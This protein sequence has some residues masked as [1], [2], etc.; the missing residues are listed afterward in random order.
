VWLEQVKRGRFERH[1]I[2]VGRPRHP[3]LDVGDVDGDGDL[4][5]VSGLFLLQ[6]REQT[7]LEVWENLRRSPARP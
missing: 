7:W 6:G 4:D 1:A 2:A 5:L 3:T